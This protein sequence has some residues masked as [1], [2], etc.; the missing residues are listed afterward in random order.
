MQEIARS[1]LFFMITS[2]VVLFIGALLIVC[3][4]YVLKIIRDINK[5]TTAVREESLQIQR[6]MD[7]VRSEFKGSAFR[8]LKWFS[9]IK[10]VVLAYLA[11][12][13]KRTKK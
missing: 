9:F 5:I 4:G 12:R 6:D 3:I 11:F 8:G 13:Q 7:E 1:D 2:V 10:T